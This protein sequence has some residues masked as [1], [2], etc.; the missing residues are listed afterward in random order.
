MCA[1]G[2]ETRPRR[3]HAEK[4]HACAEQRH[5]RLE[6]WE[7]EGAE[8]RHT[9]AGRETAPSRDTHV[10]G[11]THAPSRDTPPRTLGERR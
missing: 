9:N 3:T 2:L 6:R 10:R 7:R 4:R 11:D 8:Q 1:K 5:T